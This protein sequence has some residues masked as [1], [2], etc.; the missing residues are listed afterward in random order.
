MENLLIRTFDQSIIVRQGIPMQILLVARLK[1]VLFTTK[2]TVANFMSVHRSRVDK[3][4][5]PTDTRP[6]NRL[7]RIRVIAL[8]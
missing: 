1:I 6:K 7:V 4:F 3:R 5:L 2:Y 8:V